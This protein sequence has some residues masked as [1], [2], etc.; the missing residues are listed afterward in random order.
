[1]EFALARLA[2]SDRFEA[3]V[4]ADLERRGYGE[5]VGA[6]MERL[7]VRRLV[8]DLRVAEG[9]VRS[10]AGKRACGD[11]KLRHELER[12]G[13][14]AQCIAEALARAVPERDRAAAW[15]ETQRE[16]RGAP[17]RLARQL[18]ARGFSEETVLAI[19]EPMLP[20]GESE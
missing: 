8:D 4:A 5:H 6:V 15:L 14:D 2:L 10:R 18:A 7:R 11:A 17:Q 20:R 3:E 13:A 16:P 1:M 19:V 12:R 9:F